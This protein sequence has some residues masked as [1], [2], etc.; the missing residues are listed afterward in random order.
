MK[1]EIIGLPT[2]KKIFSKRLLHLDILLFFIFNFRKNYVKEL[3]KSAIQKIA[4]NKNLFIYIF[5][6]SVGVKVIFI[7]N[8]LIRLCQENIFFEIRC[9]MY[10]TICWPL[11]KIIKKFHHHSSKITTMDTLIPVSYTHLTLPT[12]YSV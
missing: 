11:K 3:H 7:Q 9:H 2:K 12:I 10:E 6:R 5:W 4:S 8:S 1:K